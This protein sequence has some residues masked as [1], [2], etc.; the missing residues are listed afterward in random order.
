MEPNEL[1]ERKETSTPLFTG[2]IVRLEY[3]EVRLPNGNMATREVIRHRGAVAVVALTDEGEILLE[4][5]YR[6]PHAE[7]LWEI[8]AGKLETGEDPAEAVKRELQ[9]ETGAVAKE[10]LPLGMFYPSPAIL[11]EKI[12]LY[13]A[14]GL[15]FGKRHLDADEFLAVERVP[16]ARAV[17][18]I[19]RG[20][21]PDGKTQAA[22][23]RVWAM[24]KK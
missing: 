4:R 6:Y 1:I 13:L 14:R 24:Q 9:E 16:L 10:W 17:E 2:K 12:R 11:D 20:E 3:D 7:V 5:Q 15:T 8:P 19:L 22:V 21:I 23:L 18:M